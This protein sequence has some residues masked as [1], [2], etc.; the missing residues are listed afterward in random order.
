MLW[1]RWSSA[2]K[3]SCCL[4]L[5]LLP[6]G[7]P[8]LRFSAGF[9]VLRAWALALQAAFSSALRTTC[10]TL[11]GY[12]RRSRTLISENAKKANPGIARWNRLEK[13]RSNPNVSFPALLTTTSSA[14]KMYSSSE[15]QRCC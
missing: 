12:E 10:S 2:F 13:T 15:C 11:T 8:F 1:M 14:A 3:T 4:S 9:F 5:F 7:R 6:L